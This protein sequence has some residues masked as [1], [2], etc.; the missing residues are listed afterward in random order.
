[1]AD[2]ITSCYGGRNRKVCEAFVHAKKVC[3]LF[4]HVLISHFQSLK[5][6]EEELLNGQSAQGPLTAAEV[7]DLLERT[8]DTHK[9]PLFTTVHKICQGHQ[10]A[11]E[12]IDCLK[13]HPEHQ[14]K[15]LYRVY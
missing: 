10:P 8:D 4:C 14:K 2:L 12:L 9:F 11:K 3:F 6:V 5:L 7:H 15:Q 13:H 1:M